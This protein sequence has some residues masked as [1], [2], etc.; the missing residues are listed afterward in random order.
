MALIVFQRFFIL[1]GNL[2]ESHVTLFTIKWRSHAGFGIA[3]WGQI[4]AGASL[5]LL[6]FFHCFFLLFQ[7]LFIPLATHIVD[8]Q[9]H[10]LLGKVN[11]LHA[12]VV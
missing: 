9:V 10:G 6:F 1:T 4:Y 3:A 8:T 5:C 7:T 11:I 12:L 2:Q